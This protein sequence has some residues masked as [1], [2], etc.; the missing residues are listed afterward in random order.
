[1][2]HQELLSGFIR[3]HVLHHA[4]EGNL[5][6]NW[7]IEELAHHGYRISPGTLYPMLH[8]MERKGYLTSRVERAGRSQR[9]IYRA[10]PYGMEA[11]TMAREKIRELFHEVAPEDRGA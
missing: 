9:R 2:E 8:A 11:L 6:G 7:M 3:P 4:A 10:T 5:Y 1:M